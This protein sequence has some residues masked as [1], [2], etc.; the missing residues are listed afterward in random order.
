VIKDVDERELNF[1]MAPDKEK[2]L[3]KA[4]ASDAVG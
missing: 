3:R 2:K 1:E 4:G